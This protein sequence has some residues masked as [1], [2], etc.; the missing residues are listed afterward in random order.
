MSAW[1]KFLEEES[2]YQWISFAVFTFVVIIGAVLI[3][4]SDN[5]SGFHEGAAI[6]QKGI[7]HDSAGDAIIFENDSGKYVS[8]HDNEQEA[9]Y[10]ACLVQHLH[11]T[12]ACMGQE[13][14]IFFSEENH[15]ENY[16]WIPMSLGKDVVAKN[17]EANDDNELLVIIQDGTSDKLAAMR[18]SDGQGLSPIANQDGSMHLNTILATD[19]GWLVGGSWQAPPNWLGT[20]PASPPMFELVMFVEWDGIN[21]PDSE[22]IYLGGEGTIH[23]IYE[24][25]NGNHIATGTDD[26]VILDGNDVTSLNIASFSS[27]AD[28]NQKVWLFGGL[29]SDSVAIIHNGDIDYEELPSNLGL[30]PNYVFCDSDGLISVYGT[31]GGDSPSA[32][33]IESN[34]RTSILSLRGVLD[35]GFILF[36]I[37]IISVMVWNIADSIRRGEVF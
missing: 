6:E 27:V 21:A 10:A 35:L 31:D 18:I 29:N 17:V 16:G 19:N 22:I 15:P 11:I 24:M 33:S 7:I 26:T 37:T 8:L 9:P 14:I 28:N 2:E 34:A 32:V 30:T 1:R 23:G 5:L 20:N 36:S 3:D 25:K 4:W 13:G 12:F